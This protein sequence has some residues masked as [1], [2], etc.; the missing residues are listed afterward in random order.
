L[1]YSI[2]NLTP[3]E[4]LIGLLMSDKTYGEVKKNVLEVVDRLLTYDGTYNDA[5]DIDVPALDIPLPS[6]PAQYEGNFLYIY[7]LY[8][9]T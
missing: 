9:F 2:N 7:I 8:I 5:M 4:I 3:I 6:L 1:G